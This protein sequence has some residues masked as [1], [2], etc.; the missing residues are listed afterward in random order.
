MQ[1]PRRLCSLEIWGI[2]AL[3][4]SSEFLFVNK[5]KMPHKGRVAD[6]SKIMKTLYLAYGSNLNVEQMAYR[7]PTAKIV[8]S[9]TLDNY[10]LL[11]K[12]RHGSAVATI[13]PCEGF[14]VPVL[15]WEIS[16]CD[17]K[18]LDR[19]EGYPSLYRKEKVK[20]KIGKKAIEVMVYI[21]N[22]LYEENLPSRYYYGTILDGYMSA[23]FD[24]EILK[25]ALLKEDINDR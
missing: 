11:F 8:A 9:T 1:T 19:Y 22:D 17:E 25:N 10:K 13:E 15:I 12:G 7:C 18:A 2:N 3:N 20:V 5:N 21:M 23:N 14:T 16:E 4:F 24:E 6:R